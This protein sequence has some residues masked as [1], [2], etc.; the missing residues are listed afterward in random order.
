MQ[1]GQFTKRGKCARRDF[2]PKLSTI[3]QKTVRKCALFAQFWAGFLHLFAQYLV[4][5][6]C[7]FDRNVLYLYH[8]KSK[9]FFGITA[10]FFSL[11]IRCG[12]HIGAPC[13][14]NCAPARL[15]AGALFLHFKLPCDSIPNGNGNFWHFPSYKQKLNKSRKFHCNFL[16]F[17]LCVGGAR[18]HLPRYER[19]RHLPPP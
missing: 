5:C 12:G 14:L 1:N 19:P 4:Q 2:S 3:T 15:R 11:L 18:G 17:G 13:Q 16:L 10:G 6:H 8:G 9:V 7:F